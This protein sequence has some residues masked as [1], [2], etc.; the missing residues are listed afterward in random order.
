[1]K[2]DWFIRWLLSYLTGALKAGT[3]PEHAQHIVV[4]VFQAED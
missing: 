4:R 1:M 3:T 2:P